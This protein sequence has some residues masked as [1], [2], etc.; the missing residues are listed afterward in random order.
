[1]TETVLFKDTITDLNACWREM[2]NNF[3]EGDYCVSYLRTFEF[4]LSPNCPGRMVWNFPQ[5]KELEA[6]LPLPRDMDVRVTAETY[7]AYMMVYEQIMREIGLIDKAP[8]QE[9]SDD[10]D[11]VMLG[12]I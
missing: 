11:L 7:M 6:I 1:M 10:I 12:G 3:S 5:Y 4:V 9:E 2:V 8:R